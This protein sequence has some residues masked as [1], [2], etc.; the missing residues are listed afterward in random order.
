MCIRGMREARSVGMS[1]TAVPAKRQEKRNQSAFTSLEDSTI[2]M[3][4]TLSMTQ[5][6][7]VIRRIKSA[8]ALRKTNSAVF[9]G[10]AATAASAAA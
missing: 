3:F 6:Y 10:E 2:T 1:D 7:C 9:F 8:T 5:A 4:R